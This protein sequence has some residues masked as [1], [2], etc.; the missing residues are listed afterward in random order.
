MPVHQVYSE[1]PS[2]N[3]RTDSWKCEKCD[4][5]SG[6]SALLANAER[7]LAQAGF[8]VPNSLSAA[9][10]CPECFW[11]LTTGDEP[12]PDLLPTMRRRRGYGVS[13]VLPGK[14]GPYDDTSPGDENATRAREGN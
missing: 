12:T 2:M 7:H 6:W 10:F 14:Y 8:H 4:D 3:Q 1:Q 13:K 9:D 5:D 11:E